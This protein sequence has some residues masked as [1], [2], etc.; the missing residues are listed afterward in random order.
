MLTKTEIRN[1]LSEWNKAWDRH[2]LDKVMDLFHDDIYFENWTGGTVTGKEALRAAW[3]GWFENHGGFRFIEEDT[4]IDEAE[5]KA[6][7]QWVLE[8][9]S[10]E[11]DAKGQDE[12]RKGVDVLCFEKGKII[13][14]L[15]YSKTTIEI[16]GKKRAL[17]L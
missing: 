14:K 8:W 12:R 5:Q 9:P 4:F 13:A 3:S 16:D 17:T 7:F 15:T 11:P 10:M 6:L 1:T 2:D